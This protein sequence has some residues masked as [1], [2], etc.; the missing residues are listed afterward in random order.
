M[1]EDIL[2]TQEHFDAVRS[3]SPNIDFTKRVLPYAAEAQKFDLKPWLG[4]AMYFDMLKN[5][6]STNYLL[7][8]NGGEYDDTCTPPN[9]LRFDGIRAAIA[10]YAMAR[11]RENQQVTDTSFGVVRKLNEF[12][13]PVDDKTIVRTAAQLRKGGDAIMLDVKKFLC[14]KSTDYP[15]YTATGNENKTNQSRTFISGVSRV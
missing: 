15:K 13:E 11:F 4:D 10:Y 9:T 1:T 12:S 5:Q 3:L 2:I 6:E 7:L 14:M 8:L